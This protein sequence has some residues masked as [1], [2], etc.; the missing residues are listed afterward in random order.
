[1]NEQLLQS[2]PDVLTIEQVIEIL[3][4]GKNY[5]YKIVKDEIGARKIGKGLKILK[6]DL[7]KYLE[8]KNE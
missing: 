4:I 5:A 1:M 6:R 3:G 7:I 8:G 2:Y